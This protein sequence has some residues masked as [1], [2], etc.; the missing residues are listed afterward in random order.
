M[1]QRRK[2]PKKPRRFR[3]QPSQPLCMRRAPLLIPHPLKLVMKATEAVKN[4][5][6]RM[7]CWR[8][9]D[10]GGGTAPIRANLS[11]NAGGQVIL[12]RTMTNNW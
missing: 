10:L 12:T 7:K 3:L 1:S 9:V 11:Q 5:K 4:E 2:R 8:T 6:M